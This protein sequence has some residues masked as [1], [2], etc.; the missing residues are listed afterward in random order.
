[1]SAWSALQPV[2]GITLHLAT[3]NGKLCRLSFAGRGSVFLSE[4]EGSF[5]PEEWRRDETD[6]V[7]HESQRQIRAYFRRE[8]RQFQIPLEWRGTPF[9]E[10]V[11][12]T[13]QAIPYGET[14]SYQQVA[15]AVGAPKASRAAGAACG[16]N[17]L[18]I[19][20]PCHRVVAADGGLCGFGGGLSLKR[21]LLEL[22]SVTPV[23]RRP[24]VRAASA[25]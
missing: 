13:L 8:L 9:Q 24:P 25:G 22:E 4:L 10:R 18:A 3:R 20:V 16:A 7:L 2:P 5:P 21:Y 1:M 15:S 17:P 12:Q 6:P 23:R 14:R 19:V 11:W